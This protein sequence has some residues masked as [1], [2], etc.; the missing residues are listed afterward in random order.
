MYSRA[1]MALSRCLYHRSIVRLSKRRNQVCRC[2]AQ[3]SVCRLTRLYDLTNCSPI[4]PATILIAKTSFK[5]AM[6]L[7]SKPCDEVRCARMTVATSRATLP[8]T[9]RWH[10]MTTKPIDPLEQSRN[11]SQPSLSPNDMHD[12][13]PIFA[14]I[15]SRIAR[16]RSPISSRQSA[17]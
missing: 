9:L 8:L 7:Y 12:G 13:A 16:R 6:V 5:P 15:L 11:A 4:V 17:S 10:E 3:S 1:Q 14:G 2:P